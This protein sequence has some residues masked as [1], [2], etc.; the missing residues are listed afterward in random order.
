VR[1]P[2]TQEI[3]KLKALTGRP[4]KQQELFSVNKWLERYNEQ[5]NHFLDGNL[6]NFGKYA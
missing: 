1:F 6:S 4:K 5:R 3:T 2:G